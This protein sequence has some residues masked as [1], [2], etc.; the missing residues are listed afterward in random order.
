MT[1]V[2][3]LSIAA[4]A[5]AGFGLALVLATPKADAQSFG[6][7]GMIYVAAATAGGGSQMW[8]IDARTSQ[9]ILCATDGAATKINCRSTTMPGS[10]NR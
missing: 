9:V 3:V 7:S 6:A 8:A 5:A 4:A 2:T 1:R 10:A